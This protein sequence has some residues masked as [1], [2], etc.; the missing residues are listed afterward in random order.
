[1]INSENTGLA[2][3]RHARIRK[4]LQERKIVTV[5][6]LCRELNVSGATIR[7]DLVD[8]DRQGRVR[9]VRGGAVSVGWHAEEPLFEDKAAIAAKE[10]QRIAEAALRYVQPKGSIFLDGGSTVLALARL[11]TERAGLTVVTNSLRVAGA[12]SGAGPRVILTGGELR[13]LSQTFVGSM[14]APLINQIH[15]D[16]AFMGTIGLSADDGLTTT[17]PR[18]AF[19]KNIAMARARQVILLAD[20]SK[21]GKVSFVKFGSLPK[22][23]VLITDTGASARDVQSFRK[24]GIRVVKVSGVRCRGSGKRRET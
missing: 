16:T 20:S 23:D 7:R 12:L 9:R 10:K 6:G 3:E 15:V 18:E 11:L 17:D 1:M 21:L 2:V 14:T 4:I 5:E 19:T 13:R 8:L 24:A 22:A